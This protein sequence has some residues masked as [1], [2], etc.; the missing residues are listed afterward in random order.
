M[1]LVDMMTQLA[2]EQFRLTVRL[3]R[4]DA[5]FRGVLNELNAVQAEWLRIREELE[6]HIREHQC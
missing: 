3:S 5:D 2:S 4:A 6:D 1:A